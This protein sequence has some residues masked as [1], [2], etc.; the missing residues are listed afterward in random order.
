MEIITHKLFSIKLRKDVNVYQWQDS[1]MIKHS[2]N[3]VRLSIVN[4]ALLILL[5]A[6]S[7]TRGWGFSKID[8]SAI[9]EGLIKWVF[10]NLAKSN[11]VP[12]VFN[13]PRFVKPAMKILYQ[14]TLNAFVKKDMLSMKINAPLVWCPTAYIVQLQQ[15]RYVENV[16]AHL[17]WMDR[18]LNAC[19]LLVKEVI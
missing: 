18:E 16:K 6:M 1:I 14:S 13:H 17:S 7:A 9:K 4:L 12:V 11:T 2:V 3:H 5:S 15:I 8:V 19:V 10:V